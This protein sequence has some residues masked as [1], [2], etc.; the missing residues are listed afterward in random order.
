MGVK[1][2][3]FADA[4]AEFESAYGPVVMAALR[5]YAEH[6]KADAE[7]VQTAYDEIKDDPEK[8]AAQDK[9]LITTRGLIQSAEMFQ[10]AA[11]KADEARAAFQDLQEHEIFS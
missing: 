10:D 5:A 2:V 8:C 3:K 4:F 1:V 9:S 7:R 11:L 6:M